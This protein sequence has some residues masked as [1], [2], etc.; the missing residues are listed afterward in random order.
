MKNPSDMKASAALLLFAGVVAAWPT[1]L[2]V[3]HLF[4]A[5]H[6]W[7]IINWGM[8]AIHNAQSAASS[9]S[10]AEHQLVFL[11]AALELLRTR[12]GDVETHSAT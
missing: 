6:W 5:D 10:P 8:L 7:T 9:R 3:A 4:V 11:L 1:F 2:V 12:A